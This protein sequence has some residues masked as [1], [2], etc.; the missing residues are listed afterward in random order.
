MGFGE[1]VCP[2]WLSDVA[3]EQLCALPSLLHFTGLP[4]IFAFMCFHLLVLGVVYLFSAA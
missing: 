1:R 3:V 4:C 2:T